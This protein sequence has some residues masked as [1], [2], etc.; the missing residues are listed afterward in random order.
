MVNAQ[1]PQETRHQW[2]RERRQRKA[3]N[4]LSGGEEI[5]WNW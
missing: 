4:G 3:S 1:G 2:A 5:G